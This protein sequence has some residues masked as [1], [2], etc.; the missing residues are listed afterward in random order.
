[1]ADEVY[2]TKRMLLLRKLT[3]AVADLLRGQV[4]EYLL[5][6]GPLLRPRSILG[7][8]VQ[9]GVKEPVPGADKALKELKAL[10]EP[11]A[12][13]KLFRLPRELPTPLEVST[14]VLEV[15]PV[16]YIHLAK[17]EPDSKKVTVTSP[18]KWVLS[19]TGFTPKRLREL[20]ADKNRA[21]SDLREFLLHALMIHVVLSRQPGLAKVL[22]A[23]HFS[24]SSG[25]HPDFGD[26]PFSYLTSSVPTLLPPDEVII[27][28]TEIS[29]TEVFEEV[30]NIPAMAAMNDPFKDRL[31]E[32]IQSHGPD[33]LPR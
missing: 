33:L 30:V 32:L 10:Y 28:S 24:V 7:D 8:F 9:S 2:T 19:Y 1:M 23:L 5:V 16:E 21:D 13:S 11:M 15:T 14:S 27:E 31:L 12:E 25:K 26:L 3:R 29:G 6:F 22:E 18:L 20:L 4:K 17:A